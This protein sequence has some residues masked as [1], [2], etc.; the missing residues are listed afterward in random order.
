MEQLARMLSPGGFDP[1]RDIAATS[2]SRWPHG[3]AGR[4]IPPNWDETLQPW[5]LGRQKFGQIAIANSDSGAS[6]PT[7]TAIDQAFRAI[8]ELITD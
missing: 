8:A 6:A 5:E 3:Y 4:D 1:A 2:V 7:Q